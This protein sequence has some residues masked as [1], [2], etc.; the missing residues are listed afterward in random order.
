MKIEDYI[1]LRK[2]RDGLDE[3][4]R[5][6]K[7]ENIRKLIDYIFDYYKLLEEGQ[8]SKKD[9]VKELR[10]NVNYQYEIEPYSENTQSWL[11]KIFGQYNIKI[12]RQLSKILD[13][14]NFF[15]LISEMQDW[16]KLS[17]DLY[18]T[19]TEKQK[20]LSEYPMEILEFAKD[21]YQICNKESGLAISQYKLN[22]KSKRFIKNIYSEYGVNLVAWSKFYLQYFY[23]KVTLW[24]VS[25]RIEAEENGKRVVRYNLKVSRNT[26]DLNRVLNKIS[27]TNGVSSELK[28]NKKIL[29]ALL[30]EVSDKNHLMKNE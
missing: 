20:F 3:T 23:S 17:Y 2:K 11:L 14:I 18:T 7:D 19:V 26:F 1:K 6:K 24:P 9:Q 27:D 12:N 28:K 5:K 4:D 29:V 15:L 21:Y 22:Q 13:E 25:H 8:I 10:R 30:R 16:E